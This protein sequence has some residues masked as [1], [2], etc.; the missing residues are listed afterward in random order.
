MTKENKLNLPPGTL[1]YTGDYHEE[2]MSIEWITYDEESFLRRSVE[3]IDEV[4]FASPGI[5]WLNIYGLTH[6]PTIRTL[7]QQFAIDKMTLED[8][9]HVSS[10][11][12]LDVHPGYLFSIFKMVYNRE[13]TILKEH[14]SVILKDNWLLTFQ[15]TRGDVFDPLRLRL[16]ENMGEVRN[17]GADYLYYAL[18][19]GLVDQFFDVLATLE[20]Q[21]DDVEAAVIDEEDSLIGDL[22][23]IRKELLL[24]KT[25]SSPLRGIL[26]KLTSRKV[27]HIGEDVRRYFHDV[28]DHLSQIYDQLLIQ[29]EVISNLFEVHQS[30]VDNNM[31][32]V[33]TTLTIFSAIFIPL[34]FLAGVYGMNFVT[35]PGLDHPNG[36][37]YFVAACTV[38][39]L[40]MLTFFRSR[41]WF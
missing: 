40:G 17:H 38:I 21:V 37:Y 10:R 13:E 9:V 30:N 39:A 26:M 31:N 25:A 29:R 35:F 4:D 33:M 28:N 16:E 2:T 24:I 41:E 3:S 5:H 8:I 20:V 23:T 6:I 32:R 14:L 15:E 27:E 22:Y 1:V 19:D 34:S 36:F 18:V 7:G 12:K 11:P